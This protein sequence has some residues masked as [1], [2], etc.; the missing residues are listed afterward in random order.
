MPGRARGFWR[1]RGWELCEGDHPGAG[2]PPVCPGSARRR[3]E[4]GPAPPT[5]PRP[6]H[7][8]PP[9]A[10]RP[11]PWL[12]SLPSGDPSSDLPA[13]QAVRALVSAVEAEQSGGG[14]PGSSRNEVLAGTC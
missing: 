1:G 6:I 13:R 2:W 14:V 3:E 9:T 10:S 4:G 12:L 7:S 11:R 8:A 5:Q